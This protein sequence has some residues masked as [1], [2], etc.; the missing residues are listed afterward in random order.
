M[1]LPFPAEVSRPVFIGLLAAFVLAG[2]LLRVNDLA[3][4]PP[5]ALSW[6]QGPYTDGAVVLHDTRNKVLHDEWI[7]DYCEDL[8]LFPLSNAAAYPVMRTMGASR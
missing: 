1:K 5:G 8:C 4:D 3:A 2:W 7:I 6:S